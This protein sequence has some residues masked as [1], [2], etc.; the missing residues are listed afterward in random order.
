MELNSFVTALLVHALNFVIE[1]R[2]TVERLFKS[3]EVIDHRLCPVVPALARH[4]DADPRRVNQCE[5][6]R[7]TTL[8]VSERHVVDLV[9]YQR[10][11]CLLWRDRHFRETRSAEAPPL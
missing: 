11:I 9:R 3:E 4:D 1:T 10:G 6:R 5:C 7:D 2:E 8:D